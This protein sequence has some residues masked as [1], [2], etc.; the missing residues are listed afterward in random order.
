[1]KTALKLTGALLGITLLTMACQNEIQ[2]D[3]KVAN[4]MNQ[5]I[6]EQV[7]KPSDTLAKTQSD[8]S[9]NSELPPI[10]ATATNEQSFPEQTG[11]APIESQDNKPADSIHTDE[12][13]LKGNPYEILYWNEGE[14]LIWF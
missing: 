13:V 2:S 10:P 5:S 12:V 9:R 1:M 6:K 7:I 11:A 3:P 14:S 8:L 4:V